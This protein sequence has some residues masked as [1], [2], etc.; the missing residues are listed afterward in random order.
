[1]KG[2]V[3]EAMSM[4]LPVV[5]TSVGAQGMALRHRENAMIC[6]SPSEFADSVVEL[7]RDKSLHGRIRKN[8]LD[9]IRDMCGTAAVGKRVNEMME[10]LEGMRPRHV[11]LKEKVGFAAGILRKA[12]P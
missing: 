12:L 5:T 8:A 1:M 10:Q 4:G 9:H 3:G 7:I 2:K 11:P 6:D